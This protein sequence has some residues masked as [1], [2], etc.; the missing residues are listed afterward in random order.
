MLVCALFEPFALWRAYRL[1]PS[2]RE[3]PVA[4]LE[5]RRIA[6]VS[7]LAKNS[8]VEVGMSVT[9][10]ESRCESLVL[11]DAHDASLQPAWEALLAELYG[12][13]NRLEPVSMGRIFLDVTK[14][15]AR[16]V[17]RT[18]G[19]RVG[20]GSSQE[21][22]HL[23]ALVTAEGEANLE[24]LE[25]QRH[26]LDAIPVSTLGVLGLSRKTLE[27][28]SWLGVVTFGQLRRWSRT[29]LEHYLR[30]EGRTLL[31][32]LHGPYRKGVRGYLPPVI[33]SET[34]LFEEPALEPCEIE[35]VMGRL[36]HALVASLGDRSATRLT[37]IAEAQGLAF[38]SSRTSKQPLKGKASIFRLAS[39]ALADSGV[40][41]LGID[42]L[43]L[44]LSG[45]YRQSVQGRLWHHREDLEQAVKTVEARLPG[46]ML[47]V[48]EKDPSTSPRM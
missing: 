11:L 10:A 30:E 34:H 32:Y 44:T 25:G 21:H 46:A 19:A 42:R 41:G 24:P 38:S 39:L 27:R 20:S 8:G 7:P 16:L 28:F 43:E 18:L 48:E 4:V 13:T 9:G 26:T 31:R 15:D 36:A 17:A 1:E 29:Q 35:P 6:H 45:L 2:Y 47:R 22:A 3:K 5:G 23:L 12:L 37:L 40:Q 14:A 33:L